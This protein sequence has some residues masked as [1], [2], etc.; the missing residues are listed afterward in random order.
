MRSL[1]KIVPFV[2]V[3]MYLYGITKI[4]L[5]RVNFADLD[6]RRYEDCLLRGLQ[7]WIG[8]PQGDDQIRYWVTGLWDEIMSLVCPCSRRLDLNT[9]A[10]SLFTGG[11]QAGILAPIKRSRFILLCTVLAQPYLIWKIWFKSWREDLWGTNKSKDRK[12]ALKERK[13]LIKSQLL[14]GVFLQKNFPG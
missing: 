8:G 1:F 5:G 9:V 10:R 4:D 13:D 7:E 2:S 11:C 14:K 3:T 6:N 12:L